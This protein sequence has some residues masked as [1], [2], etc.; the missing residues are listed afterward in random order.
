MN[1][2]EK[3]FIMNNQ[4]D[5]DGDNIYPGYTVINENAKREGEIYPLDCTVNKKSGVAKLPSPGLFV[6]AGVPKV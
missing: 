3:I 5:E 6:Y 1:N 4:E 2:K